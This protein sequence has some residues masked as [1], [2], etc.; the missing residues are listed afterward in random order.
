MRTFPQMFFG[1]STPLF[2]LL[3]CLALLACRSPEER[4]ASH[5][6]RAEELATAGRTEEAILEYRSALN[7]DA[8][9][10]DVNQRIAELM[11]SQ[12]GMDNAAQ[13]FLE[14]YRLDPSRIEAAMQ[15]SKLIART[16]R[17]R[18]DEMVAA[19]LEKANDQAI[20]HR[21]VSFLS[22]LDRDMEKA[23]ESA[24]KA[25]ELDAQDPENWIQLGR[26]HHAR[27]RKAKAPNAES[28]FQESIAAFD[29]ADELRGGDVAIRL[30]RTIVIIAWKPR[31][32]D[33][34]R[35]YVETLEFA[36]KQGSDED[37]AL[38]ANA[39]AAYAKAVGDRELQ[40]SALRTFI[41]IYPDAIEQWRTLA[42]V[43][44]EPV[45]AELLEARP[46]DPRA[47]RLWA[48]FLSSQGRETEAIS[49]LDDVLSRGLESPILWDDVI[50]RRLNRAQMKLAL[51]ALDSLEDQAPDHPVTRRAR[52]RIAMAKG[53]NDEAVKLL[54]TVPAASRTSDGRRLLALAEYRRGNLNAA[55]DAI[56]QSIALS[57]EASHPAL[58][59]KARIHHDAEEWQLA[60]QAFTQLVDDDA[61][62]KPE[63]QIM[64]A[65][66]SL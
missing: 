52:A 39:L 10:A 32:P 3:C 22:I 44:G 1:R 4:F 35:A 66:S 41:A 11:I 33:V 36:Q 55:K 45:Y 12:G 14:A 46:D 17:Q 38:A 56:N 60:F 29:R 15:Y 53:E 27:A 9:S 31:S 8:S 19:A 2:A 6:A 54:R 65:R 23:L 51:S 24:Q 49:H 18:A 5:V 50:R 62:L 7:V 47:H 58:R 40:V 59:L 37:Q 25:I 21:T 16:N 64:A 13:F 42:Q 57:G 63:E 26:T 34:R 43:E 61:E 20:V 30:E 48:N 28:E